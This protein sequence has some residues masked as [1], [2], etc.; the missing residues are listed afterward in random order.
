V[1]TV[2]GL[3]AGLLTTSCWA[4]QLLRS[5]RT[6]S[7]GDISWVMIAALGSGIVLW[8]A[9]GVI[10]DDTSLIV[11]NVATILALGSLAFLKW[12]F[13]RGRIGR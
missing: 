2:L 9:Y 6:R 5:Y 1:I 13:D 3:T 12:S 10:I 8:L 11:A 7:T 4:P